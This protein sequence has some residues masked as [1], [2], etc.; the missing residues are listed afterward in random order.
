MVRR[1]GTG[2]RVF[3]EVPEQARLLLLKGGQS[4]L[5]ERRFHTL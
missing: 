3:V 1:G 5:L 2:P 4:A